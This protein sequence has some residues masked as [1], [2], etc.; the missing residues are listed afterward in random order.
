[1]RINHRRW[2]DVG[3]MVML[4]IIAT[5]ITFIFKMNLLISILL[6]FAAP[7]IYLS[8]RKPALFKK[9]FIFSLILSVPMSLSFD[10]LAAI[11]GSWVIPQSL[12]PIRFFGVATIE[13]YLFGLFWVLYAVLFYEYFFDKNRKKEKTSPHLK[14]LLYLSGALIL[15]VLLGF[16]VNE[17]LLHIPY[18]YLVFGILF[19]FGPLLLFLFSFPSF[20]YRYSVVAAYFF[21]PLFLFEI[22]ALYTGQWAF[23]GDFIGFITLFGFRFPIEE[24]IIWMIGATVALLSYYEFFDDDER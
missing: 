15:Y 21:F 5:V 8:L 6:F 9:S 4:P 12:F 2:I 24:L 1:M 14:Y 11:N 23:T 10:V 22:A 13:V 16:F 3:A 7:A 17:S 19:I 18:F 20:I